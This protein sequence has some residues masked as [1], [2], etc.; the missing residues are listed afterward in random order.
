M[1]FTLY[2]S[3]LIGTGTRVKIPRCGALNA[4]LPR[5]AGC[6][7]YML[8]TEALSYNPTS[9]FNFAAE[10]ETCKQNAQAVIEDIAHFFAEFACQIPLVS[11]HYI[12][13]NATTLVVP[14]LEQNGDVR[15]MAYK[16]IRDGS[17]RS[18][19]EF[20]GFFNFRERIINAREPSVALWASPPGPAKEHYGKY[21]FLYG[22]L[23]PKYQEGKRRRISMF[24][25]RINDFDE[26]TQGACARLLN[27]LSQKPIFSEAVTT[28]DLLL[29]PIILPLDPRKQEE[30]IND[31]GPLFSKIG[32]YLKGKF[33]QEQVAENIGQN[34]LANKLLDYVK[35]K[36]KDQIY[37]MY[38]AIWSKAHH[39]PL[40]V[41]GEQLFNRLLENMGLMQLL[42][43]S[44]PAKFSDTD[45]VA[46]KD[47]KEG[48]AHFCPKCGRVFKGLSC[49]HCDYS[50]K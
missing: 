38:N 27:D 22:A 10:I 3:D 50:L 36:Y 1:G 46:D 39:I 41:D 47:S 49:P 11:Y 45:I 20:D 13:T 44:C 32:S 37:E 7:I 40:E 15:L 42:A 43:G 6:R 26:A 12:Q 2:H 30:P 18:R 16:G 23:I 21:G 14:G 24:A 31:I 48:E 33:D 8:R 5:L 19:Q 34:G 9:Q 4:P 29:N 17:L 35:A 25:L 28:T